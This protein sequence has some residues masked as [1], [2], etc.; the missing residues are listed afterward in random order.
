MRISGLIKLFVLPLAVLGAVAGGLVRRYRVEGRSMLQTYAPGDRLLVERLSYRLR[1]PRVGEAVILRQP[2]TGGRLD[3]KRIAAGPGAP[4]TVGGIGQVLGDDEWY[5]LGDNL[6][7][8][9]DSR[10][11]GPVRRRDVVGRMWLRY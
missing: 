3:L 5:V 6:S 8:S 2:R 11:L 9:T 1:A 10:A 7:E 4:V